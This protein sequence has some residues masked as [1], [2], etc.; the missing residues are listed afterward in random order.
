MEIK[1]FTLK[2]VDNLKK[3]L[4]SVDL[5]VVAE[6]VEQIEKVSKNKSKFYVIGNGGSSATASHWANDFAIGLKRRNL[7]SIDMVSLEI[8]RAHV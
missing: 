3:H 4:D 8:G 2:Y 5:D 1:E 6:I 7:L